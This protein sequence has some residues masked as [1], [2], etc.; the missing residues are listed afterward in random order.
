MSQN[1]E[2][3]ENQS[4]TNDYHTSQAFLELNHDGRQ[5]KIWTHSFP[6]QH[7]AYKKMRKLSEWLGT[8]ELRSGRQNLRAISPQLTEADFIL[9]IIN[10]E[11]NA[12][13]VALLACITG[14]TGMIHG[15][16]MQNGSLR[17]F[18]TE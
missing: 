12:G 18:V 3:S 4:D 5:Q 15:L 1:N 9:K 11:W 8:F 7:A 17:I 6:C 13:I 14:F 10:I 16:G 2:D